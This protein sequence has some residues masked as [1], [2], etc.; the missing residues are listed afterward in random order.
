M[1]TSDHI[2]YLV[3]LCFIY[4]THNLGRRW[5]F[6]KKHINITFAGIEQI[7][8]QCIDA[9]Y[10][11]EVLVEYSFSS[12]S[13]ERHTGR[14]YIRIDSFLKDTL[15][16]LSEEKGMPVLSSNKG[17][18]MGEELIEH[19]L[20]S[21]KKSILIEYYTKNPSENRIYRSGSV[22][23]NLFQSSPSFPWT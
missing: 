15:L 9:L 11:P 22:K 6:T 12:N 19:Y 5:L 17:K 16:I 8:L 3:I 1:L 14:D 10:S 13:G 23:E 20:L 21:Y 18:Y 2:I 4:L 7:K